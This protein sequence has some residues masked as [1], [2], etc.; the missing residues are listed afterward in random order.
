MTGLRGGTS[1]R[2]DADPASDP[3]PLLS[4]HD[5]RIHFET[6]RGAASAVDGVSFDIAEGETLAVGET[7]SGKSVTLGD[8]RC[9]G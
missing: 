8:A 5:L 6:K 3:P 9:S 7:G 2:E 1:A 4:V